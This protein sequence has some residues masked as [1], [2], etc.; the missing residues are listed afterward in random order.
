MGAINKAASEQEGKVHRQDGDDHG[1]PR[2]G[3][4]LYPRRPLPISERILSQT[5]GRST[6]YFLFFKRAAGPLPVRLGARPLTVPSGEGAPSGLAYQ[7]ADTMS[8]V[9]LPARSWQGEL[10]NAGQNPARLGARATRER[11]SGAG[12]AAALRV[13]ATGREPA[14]WSSLILPLTARI[15]AYPQAEGNPCSTSLTAS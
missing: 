8:P 4:P 12:A 13:R 11:N 15:V 9:P 7:A 6:E 3:A 10:V 2:G 14:P 1:R 5:L